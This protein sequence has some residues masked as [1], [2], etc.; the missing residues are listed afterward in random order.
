MFVQNVNNRVSIPATSWVNVLGQSFKQI[1]SGLNGAVWGVTSSNE[2]FY[3][4]NVTAARPTGTDWVR[5]P[6]RMAHVTVG[7]D[8]VYGVDTKHKIFRFIG[9]GM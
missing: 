2:I 8:G 6:G 7:C 3:R 1:D 4:A 5:V 9:T